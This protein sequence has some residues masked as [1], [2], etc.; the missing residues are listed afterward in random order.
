MRHY[1][2]S[3]MVKLLSG[4]SSTVPLCNPP[5]FDTTF[6]WLPPAS[7]GIL[8][9]PC[10]V[11]PPRC[12][13]SLSRLGTTCPLSVYLSCGFLPT[14]SQLQLHHACIDVSS[15]LSFLLLNLLA[16][17]SRTPLPAYTYIGLLISTLALPLSYSR[18][19]VKY[20]VL[21]FGR[22]TSCLARVRIASS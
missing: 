15:S 1:V 22:E 20:N 18:G 21:F 10:D 11:H 12:T 16:W 5:H 14:Q 6:S 4:P 7:P 17:L 8:P 13:S 2:I 9:Q 3:H 19:G